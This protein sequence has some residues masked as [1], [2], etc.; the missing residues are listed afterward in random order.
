MAKRIQPTK[1]SAIPVNTLGRLS[2]Y[3]RLLSGQ[4]TPV[5]RQVYSH[6]LAG[7]AVTTAAQVRRDLMTIGVS[8]SPRKGYA[9]AELVAVIDE[10]L[11]RS[12]ETAVALVGI[13]NLGRAI[14]AY[15]ANRRPIGFAAAFDRAPEK[16][17]RVLH[18]C[19]C[20]PSDQ[21]AEVVAREDIHVGVIAVPAPEA[22]A[23]CDQLVL[24]G[25]TGILNFAP[26]RLRVPAGLHVENVDLMMALDRVAYFAH[27]RS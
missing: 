2:L 9:T 26:V 24:A 19:R 3:R 20:Y 18:G 15:Y 11:L 14:L 4:F 21:I 16:T 25:V 8:G 10:V 27:E 22:Q 23:V 1:R 12:V 13:G 17:G 5:P 7:L 6:Q